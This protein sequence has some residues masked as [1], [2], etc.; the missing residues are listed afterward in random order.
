MEQMEHSEHVE[1]MEHLPAT[2]REAFIQASLFLQQHQVMDSAICAELL[3]GHLLSWDRTT[4]LMNWHEPFPEGCLGEWKELIQRKAS[5][6]P[7]QY[8]IGE[9][10]FYG[11][12]LH[13]NPNVL[14]PRPET[15][16][17]VE[18]IIRRGREIWGANGS[19]ELDGT[20]I[21]EEKE[22]VARTVRTERVRMED[23]VP[24]VADIGSGSG[25]ICVSLAVLCP[26]WTITSSD[27]SHGAL[28][29]ARSNAARNGVEGQ[30]VFYQGDLLE[31]YIK[32]KQR[33]D[34]LV[35]NPPYIP[36]GDLGQLQA[37]VKQYEPHLALD[38]GEDGLDLYRRMIDQMGLLPC[39]PSLVGFEVGQG[40]DEAVARM[41]DNLHV[42]NQVV[43]IADLA[44]I[45]RHVMAIGLRDC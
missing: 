6:E 18:Q 26:E 28:G 40:Q 3:L 37:E 22:E 31:P 29:V 10:E 17:L 5:G 11:L 9:Q 21:I 16:V 25:A 32:T 24:F 33:I 35:S 45:Q 1:L 34:I 36:V 19:E 4:L 39:Y 7:V 8:I 12:T 44:G 38:G 23:K 30:I 42:W 27:L 2:V 43:T 41:L 14:I 15:E 20:G 13:V